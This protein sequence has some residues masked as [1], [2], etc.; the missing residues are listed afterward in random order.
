MGDI[1]KGA[2]EISYNSRQ[3]EMRRAVNCLEGEFEMHLKLSDKM[4]L[5]REI[6][7]ARKIQLGVLRD[8]EEG[9]SSA[10]IIRIHRE[11]VMNYLE[12]WHGLD[13]ANDQ[14]DIFF[15]IPSDVMLK[16]IS[17]QQRRYD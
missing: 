13:S 4:L 11:A 16:K 3:R 5:L 12:K 14:Q 15:G 7:E 6:E 9:G 1:L 8:A 17:S 10:G 2:V